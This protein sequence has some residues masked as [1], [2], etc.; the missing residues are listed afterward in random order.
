MVS[1][2]LP[3]SRA[4]GL[5]LIGGEL[6]LDFANTCSGRDSATFQDHFQRPEHVAQWAGHAKVLP[7]PD[8]QWLAQAVATQ[9]VLGERLLA[10]PLALREDVYRLGA[11]LAAGASPPA[12]SI[13]R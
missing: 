8:A 7:P 11:G 4:G 10:A 3:A 9:P 12:D 2:D 13:E 6:A 5:T 1:S